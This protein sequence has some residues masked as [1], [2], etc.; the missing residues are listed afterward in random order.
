MERESQRRKVPHISYGWNRPVEVIVGKDSGFDQER[1]RGRE[2][3]NC[4]YPDFMLNFLKSGRSQSIEIGQ[5]SDGWWDR[6]GE[7]IVKEMSFNYNEPKPPRIKC[8]RR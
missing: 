1:G 5:I 8:K 3:E 4:K 7:T 6:P 2:R